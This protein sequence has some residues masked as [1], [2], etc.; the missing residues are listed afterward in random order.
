MESI[1]DGDGHNSTAIAIS[2]KP[3]APCA[4]YADGC[5]KKHASGQWYDFHFRC[6][7]GKEGPVLIWLHWG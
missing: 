2:G 1:D 4:R 5:Q 7:V 3:N 6:I